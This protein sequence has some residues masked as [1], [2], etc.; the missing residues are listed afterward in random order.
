MLFANCEYFDDISFL[1]DDN[2]LLELF[3]KFCMEDL[4]LIALK[5][6]V[7]ECSDKF[8]EMASIYEDTMKFYEA[9]KRFD[10]EV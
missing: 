6:Q 8:S 9:L 3:Q 7:E 4:Q 10:E 1:F 2:A 5:L